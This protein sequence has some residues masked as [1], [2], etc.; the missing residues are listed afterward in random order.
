[1]GLFLPFE[2]SPTHLINAKQTLKPPNDRNYTANLLRPILHI[3]KKIKQGKATRTPVSG[4]V[5]VPSAPVPFPTCGLDFA[6]V[7]GGFPSSLVSSEFS[8]QS[9]DKTWQCE[10]AVPSV[11]AISVSAC[12]TVIPCLARIH[13]AISDFE[14]WH[15]KKIVLL[16]YGC[17]HAS[18]QGPGTIQERYLAGWMREAF[19]SNQ[20]MFHG[21]AW[22]TEPPN[23]TTGRRLLLL[24]F[25][26][27]PKEI[28]FAWLCLALFGCP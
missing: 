25:T 12:Y 19:A 7:I 16:H 21:Y 17:T 27:L 18:I 13:C 8:S 15:D 22:P 14:S 9:F 23:T 4:F 10:A 20:I 3:L 5:H 24:H 2:K 26:W 28:S 6:L 11:W 1:M